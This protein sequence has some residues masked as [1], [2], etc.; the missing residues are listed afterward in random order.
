MLRAVRKRMTPIP[1]DSCI[2]RVIYYSAESREESSNDI[3]ARLTAEGVTDSPRAVRH[4]L[5]DAD[6]IR[7]L[8][9]DAFA[10][11]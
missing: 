7:L 11:S 3:W 1:P 4:R 6:S 2:V 9:K 10:K 8:Q 5:F